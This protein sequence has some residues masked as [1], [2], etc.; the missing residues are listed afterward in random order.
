[1]EVRESLGDVGGR[2]LRAS[3]SE[4]AQADTTTNSTNLS[5]EIGQ[6]LSSK[7]CMPQPKNTVQFQDW[8][9]ELSFGIVEVALLSS[10][11]SSHRGAHAE[12][13]NCVI[14]GS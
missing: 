2:D 4:D 7:A 8:C 12:G 13:R 5:L 9:T 1:M 14:G 11:F 6:A 3:Q 10:S